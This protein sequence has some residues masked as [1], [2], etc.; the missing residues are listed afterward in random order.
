MS[1]QQAALGPGRAN[2][3]LA[4]LFFGMFVLGS[5]AGWWGWRRRRSSAICT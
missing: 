5:A 2:L 3:A 1:T 4:T